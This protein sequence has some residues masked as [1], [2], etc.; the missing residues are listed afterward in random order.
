MEKINS[1]FIRKDIATYVPK[2]YRVCKEC[3]PKEKIIESC[4]NKE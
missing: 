2:F 4:N 1:K 3:A